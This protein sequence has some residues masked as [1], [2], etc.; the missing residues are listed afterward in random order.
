[1]PVHSTHQLLCI[2]DIQLRFEWVDTG[3][4]DCHML[5]EFNSQ[6]LPRK[7]YVRVENKAKTALHPSGPIVMSTFRIPQKVGKTRSLSSALC[8]ISGVNQALI[9]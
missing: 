4:Y 7:N 3:V 8:D 1:M 5:I 9:V 2:F 6:A